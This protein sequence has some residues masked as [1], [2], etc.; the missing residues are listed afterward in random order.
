MRSRNMQKRIINRIQQRNIKRE[1]CL[2]NFP[3]EFKE[4]L[5]NLSFWERIRFLFKP[6]CLN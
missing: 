2:I 5:L 3:L 6:D 4:L 1:Q